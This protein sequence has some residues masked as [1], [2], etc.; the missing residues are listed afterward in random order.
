MRTRRFYQSL[1][2]RITLGLLGPLLITLSVFSWMQYTDQSQLLMDSLRRSAANA[3]S[4]VEGSLQNAM[5][6]HDFSDIQQ[7]ADGIVGQQGVVDLLLLSKQGEVVLSAGNERVGTLMPLSDATCQACHRYE[8]ASR[9]ESV[10]LAGQSG[11]RVFRNVNAIENQEPC[12][13]CHDSRERLSGVLITDLSMADIDRQLAVFRRNSLLWSGGSVLLILLIVNFMMSRMVVSRLECFVEAI[14]RVGRW[15]TN[16]RVAISGSDEIGELAN[17][18]NRM[19]AGLKEKQVLEQRFEEQGSAL[20]KAELALQNLRELVSSGP[21]ATL[22]L[23]HEL[24]SPAASIYQTLDVL[25]QGYAGGSYEDQVKL[26]YLVRDRAGVMLD[27]VNDL[28]RL[29]AVRQGAETDKGVDPVQ[30]VE[31]LRNV[32]P[33]MRIKATLK[34]IDLVVDVPEALPPI[35]ATEGSMEQ[36]L[37][38]LIDNAI[39]YTD[40]GGRVIVRLRDEDDSVVGTVEDTGIG[41]APEDMSHIFDEFYRASNATRVEPYGTGLGLPI[42]KRVV[43]LYGGSI[44]V[45]S[46]LGE[47]TKFTF[48][49]P[50]LKRVGN[51]KTPAQNA[52]RAEDLESV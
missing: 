18:F 34:L 8:A 23:V 19:A 52:L 31:V 49:F 5:L 13:A 7:I 11:T 40:T 9:N 24:R 25:L 10:I 45:E 42:V 3:G 27:M 39:K 22:R 48:A 51:V 16:E 38:N 6:R 20:D 29:G 12:Q 2:F 14:A 47:G 50:K 30:L 21:A 46:E 44:Q 17:S 41:V 15:D 32:L 26:M 35:G 43:E 36:L 37:S 28:L 33:P 1:R 4:I